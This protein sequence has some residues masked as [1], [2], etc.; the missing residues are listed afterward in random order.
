MHKVDDKKRVFKS[1]IQ[2]GFFSIE[3]YWGL[4]VDAEYIPNTT[5][6]SNKNGSI[7]STLIIMLI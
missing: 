7:I 3:G 5:P 1:L 6:S 4:P 2:L